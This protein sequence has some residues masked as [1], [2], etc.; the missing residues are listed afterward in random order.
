MTKA[1]HRNS[2]RSLGRK[3]PKTSRLDGVAHWNLTLDRLLWILLRAGIDAKAI[4]S[5]V[6]ESLTRHRRTHPLKLPTPEVREYG[7]VLTFWR[8]E[9]D[10]L[11]ERGIPRALPLSRGPASF[12]ALVRRALPECQP[13]HVL[14]VLRQHKLV[15]LGRGAR[16]TLQAIEF[17]PK[18]AAREY[19]VA[20]TLTAL[21]G[22]IDTCHR[23]LIAKNPTRGIVRLQRVA[24][25]ERFDLKYLKDYD[26]FLREQAT[27]FLL[28]QD[29]WLKRH[30]AQS[31]R[32]REALV[33]HVGV[34]V[35]GFRAE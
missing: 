10:F 25:A 5:S 24:N 12:R 15:S 21:E 4:T 18:T 11:D 7:R 22:I 27:D 17:L 2:R 32:N 1:D 31:P 16:V 26:L 33:A 8:T 23:N 6:E 20:S 34:G 35:F 19:F 29:A 9:P 3:P 14:K 28:K 13:R 30:E